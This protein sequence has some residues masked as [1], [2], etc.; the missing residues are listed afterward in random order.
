M[1]LLAQYAPYEPQCSERDEA[2]AGAD[3]S[4]SPITDARLEQGYQYW[5]LKSAG[6]PLPRRADLDPTEIPKLLPDVML[7]DVL[8]AGR[9]RYRL[10]GTENARAHGI[11]ATGRYLDEVVPGAEYKNHVIAL[12]DECVRTGRALYSECLFLSPD[13]EAAQRHTKVLFLP[14]AEDGATVNMVFV[15]QVFFYIDRAIRDRHFIDIRPYKEIAH[16]LL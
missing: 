15:V 13:G 2:V 9:Y 14:L 7:V 6:K 12:Y 8:P 16:A 10:I 5:R 4:Q 1:A 3:W 11:N